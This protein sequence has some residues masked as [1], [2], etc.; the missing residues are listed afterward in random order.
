[1]KS[2]REFQRVTFGR[3]MDVARLRAVLHQT[4]LEMAKNPA[5][6]AAAAR[7]ESVLIEPTET[8]VYVSGTGPGSKASP[9]YSS[10]ISQVSRS[11]QL[12]GLMRCGSRVRWNRRPQGRSGNRGANET[13]ACSTVRRGVAVWNTNSELTSSTIKP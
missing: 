7:L 8:T 4:M 12:A 13:G 9:R 3:R 2:R 5:P 11:R 10:G 6:E 1:M